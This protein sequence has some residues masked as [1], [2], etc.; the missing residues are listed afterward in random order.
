MGTLK[1]FAKAQPVRGKRCWTCD[2]DPRVRREVER[3]FADGIS[4]PTITKWLVAE[5]HPE[6]TDARIR[7]HLKEHRA[8]A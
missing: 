1:T 6:A 8:A 7:R 2:L 5:G 3:G 4:V